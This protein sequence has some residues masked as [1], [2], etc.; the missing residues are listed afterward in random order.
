[1]WLCVYQ[2]LEEDEEV[3]RRGSKDMREMDLGDLASEDA[4]EKLMRTLEGQVH[5][6][7]G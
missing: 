4:V 3:V 7:R 1:M 6:K 2:V 5:Q